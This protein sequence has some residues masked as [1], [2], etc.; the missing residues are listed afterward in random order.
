MRVTEY[1]LNKSTTPLDAVRVGCAMDGTATDVYWHLI[2]R[3]RMRVTG[4]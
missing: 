4:K 3:V 2:G 1:I